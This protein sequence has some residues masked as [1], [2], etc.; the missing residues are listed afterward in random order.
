MNTLIQQISDAYIARLPQGPRYFSPADF[1]A[2]RFPDFLIRRIAVELENN[3]AESIVPPKTDW[4]DMQV[5]SVIA[6]WEH[7]LFAI[8]EATRMPAVHAR[9]VIETSIEDILVLLVEPRRQIVEYLFGR[10]SILTIDELA[11]RV[12]WLVVYRFLGDALLKWAR[13]KGLT[14]IERPVAER[15]VRSIDEKIV[16]VYTPLTWTQSLDELFLLV[17]E[18]VDP[19]II[20]TYFIDRGRPRIAAL[21]AQRNAAISRTELVELLSLPD[22]D[23]EPKPYEKEAVLSPEPAPLPVKPA[24]GTRNHLDDKAAGA[25]IQKTQEPEFIQPSA[26][27]VFVAPVIQSVDGT[28]RKPKFEFMTGEAT[29]VVQQPPDTANP[30]SQPV[31]NEQQLPLVPS[32]PVVPPVVKRFSEEAVNLSLTSAPVIDQKTQEV[33]EPLPEAE[34]ENPSGGT[35]APVLAGYTQPDL[36]ESQ[37]AVVAPEIARDLTSQSTAESAVPAGNDLASEVLNGAPEIP[38]PEAKAAEEFAHISSAVSGDET[39]VPVSF[40]TV[41]E[42]LSKDRAEDHGTK[43]AADQRTV[44]D[45]SVRGAQPTP[46][47]KVE[48][49][50]PA[51]SKIN[52]VT[53]AHL[54]DNEQKL[55]EATRERSLIER[56][57]ETS[58]ELNNISENVKPLAERFTAGETVPLVPP[59]PPRPSPEVPLWKKFKP[60]EEKALI[61]MTRP[62]PVAAAEVRKLER[63]LIDK[64]EY[65]LFEVFAGDEDL[66]NESLRALA[67]F[68][69]W[70]PAGRY[71]VQHIF[72][73]N[74]VDTYSEV[75]IDF[76]DQMQTY[77]LKKAGNAS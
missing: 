75:G 34:L 66:W 5:E 6:A 3:L 8:H 40:D 47:E 52:E 19:E 65:F 17:G 70:T 61:D 69:D 10:D 30:V 56:L 62:D 68:P 42:P 46:E 53:Q 37:T 11:E 9:T 49:Q 48:V 76:L 25:A 15:V 32:T 31:R 55:Q 72:R 43:P 33:P 73:L 24:A 22:F 41:I 28:S 36:A 12:G 60:V 67:T 1:K 50:T 29:P 64:K 44:L 54:N 71:I 26:S 77:F 13:K 14:V 74:K 59:P 51:D 58:A 45:T 63:H 18:R 20:S 2:A 16:C 4:A 23:D 39:A 27:A 38:I 35:T 21:L 57:K 7:F